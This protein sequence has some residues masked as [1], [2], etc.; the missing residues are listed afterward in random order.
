MRVFVEIVCTLI[1]TLFVAYL[2]LASEVYAKVRR[3]RKGRRDS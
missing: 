3:E 2:L 1:A